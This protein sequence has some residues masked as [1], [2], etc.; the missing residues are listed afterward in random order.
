MSLAWSRTEPAR[1][2]YERL[3]DQVLLSKNIEPDH[4]DGF[5]ELGL[6]GL[7]LGSTRQT[8]WQATLQGARRPP[9]TPYQDPRQQALVDAFVFVLGLEEEWK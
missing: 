9:W 2:A 6:A 8:C 7:L 4:V 3:R 1:T 5:C